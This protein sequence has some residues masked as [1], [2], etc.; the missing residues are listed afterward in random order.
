MEEHHSVD[1]AF[2]S[3]LTEIVLANLTDGNFN[4]EKLA[5]EAGISR[6]TLYRRVRSIKRQ[7]ISQFIRGVR[8]QRAMEMLQNHEGSVADIAFRI[9]FGSPTYFIKCFHDYYGFPP[10]EVRKIV[11]AESLNNLTDGQYGESGTL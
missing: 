4:V 9:G 1:Q 3:K 5:K 11:N 6:I 8:L 2:I 10:G 7:D